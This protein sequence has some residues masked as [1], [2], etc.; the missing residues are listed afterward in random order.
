MSIVNF[1]DSAKRDLENITNYSL[2]NWGKE[3]TLKY[4]DNIYDKIFDLSS[5]PDIGVLRSDL[6]SNLL[7]FPVKKHIIYYIKQVHGI[8]VVRI[9]HI[10]MYPK[11]HEFR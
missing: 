7:I 8:L 10:H 3:Q 9:L 2:K 1:T 11:I 4:L 6:Y 5:K